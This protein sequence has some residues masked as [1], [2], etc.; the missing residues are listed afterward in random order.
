MFEL[1]MIAL[2]VWLFA[3][4]VGLAFRVTWGLAKISAVILVAL[5][6]FVLLGSLLLAG[7]VIL[8]LPV[9]LIAAACGILKACI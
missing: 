1:L 7:G 6:A 9:A 8:L 2:F 4:A 5:A 3:K